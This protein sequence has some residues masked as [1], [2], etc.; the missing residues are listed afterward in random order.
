MGGLAHYLLLL[1][2]AQVQSQLQL[3][4]LVP[5]GGWGNRLRGRKRGVNL[6]QRSYL[7]QKATSPCAGKRS[8]HPERLWAACPQ[9]A[10]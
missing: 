6:A 4:V 3:Q 10:V 8:A 7:G 2:P 1:L 5:V 9:T